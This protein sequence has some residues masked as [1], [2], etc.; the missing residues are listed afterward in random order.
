VVWQIA[1]PGLTCVKLAENTGQ[2]SFL[3]GARRTGAPFG[4][5]S[6]VSWAPSWVTPCVRF[7]ELTGG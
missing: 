1:R 6:F 5:H 2:R 4:D 7:A 3:D